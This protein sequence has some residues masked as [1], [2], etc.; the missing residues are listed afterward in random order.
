MSGSATETVT[1][2]LVKFT[3]TADN[4]SVFT[5]GLN[6]VMTVLQEISVSTY[7]SNNKLGVID[8]TSFKPI[9]IK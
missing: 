6:N 5:V 8:A 9:Y 3:P 7:G 4:S 1:L 2:K